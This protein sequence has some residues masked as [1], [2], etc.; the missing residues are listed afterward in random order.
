MRPSSYPVVA[1]LTLASSIVTGQARAEQQKYEPNTL[2]ISAGPSRELTPEEKQEQERQRKE[3]EAKD[4]AEKAAEAAR[5]AQREA[6]TQRRL[7]EMN[8][9][10]QREAEARRLLEMERAA[11]A[12]RAP[13]FPVAQP[14]SGAKEEPGNGRGD[15]ANLA[16][17]ERQREAER[18][19]ERERKREAYMK[20]LAEAEKKRKKE[21]EELA[22]LARLQKTVQM[23]AKKC[24]ADAVRVGGIL[25][26]GK[27]LVEV[28]VHF[29]VACPGNLPVKGA[30]NYFLGDGYSCVGSD[31]VNVKIPCEAEKSRVVVTAVTRAN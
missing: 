16:A 11:A 14:A 29:E 5:A 12:A 6:E 3:R 1:I 15:Q 25:P 24:G 13:Q 8:V 27:R 21:Q 22:Y 10:P 18:D 2:Y 30:A 7:K 31:M 19:A 20:S 17:T 28:K 23:A 9:P 26:P 4:K